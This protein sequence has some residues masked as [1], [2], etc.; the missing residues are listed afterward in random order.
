M[1]LGDSHAAQWFATVEA[2]AIERGWRL[3]L[4]TKASCPAA[5]LT[6]WSP[7]LVRP[8]TECDEWRASAL[9]RIAAERPSLVIVSNTRYINLVIDGKPVAS[10]SQEP[11]WDAALGR[12]LAAIRGSAGAVVLL[13]DTPNPDVNPLECLAQNP[14]D[15]LACATPLS[16]SVSPTRISAESR[17]SAAAG[18]VFVDPTPWVCPSDPCP[19]V[20]GRYLV[21]RDSGHLATSFA[22]ALAPYLASA[23]PPVP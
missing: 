21:Y 19:A 12:T 23:L 16:S 3:E 14:S 1:L 22:R 4:L 5:D 2:I 20:I 9:E 13:G 15:A 7:S 11:V 10:L 18:A 6:V 17:L 8:Y